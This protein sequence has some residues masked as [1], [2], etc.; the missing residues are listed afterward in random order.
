IYEK[1]LFTHGRC[2]F[3]CVSVSLAEFRARSKQLPIRANPATAPTRAPDRPIPART[4][5]RSAAAAKRNPRQPATGMQQL[6]LNDPQLQLD[7]LQLEQQQNQLRQEQQ[8]NQLREEEQLNQSQ[9][10]PTSDQFQR[11]QQLQE[12]QQQQQIDQLRVQQ[13]SIGRGRSQIRLCELSRHA[14]DRRRSRHLSRKERRTRGALKQSRPE[15]LL[16][17]SEPPSLFRQVSVFQLRLSPGIGLLMLRIH[18]LAPRL[19]FVSDLAAFTGAC[20]GSH[21]LH[22]LAS[23]LRLPM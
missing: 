23:R 18:R 2:R 7:Q 1:V 6:Q 8:L 14:K 12:L 20:L 11:E 22:N 15:S 9:G 3:V 10:W 16:S 5:A 17:Q 13:E 4:G 21:F 19:L